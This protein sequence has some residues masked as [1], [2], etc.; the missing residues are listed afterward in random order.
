M[1][2][3]EKIVELEYLRFVVAEFVTRKKLGPAD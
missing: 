2:K 1:I 3:N